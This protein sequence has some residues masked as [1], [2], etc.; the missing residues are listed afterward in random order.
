MPT[1]HATTAASAVATAMSRSRI[2]RRGLG[3]GADWT[4]SRPTREGSLRIVHR[5]HRSGTSWFNGC[6]GAP[7]RRLSCTMLDHSPECV[8]WR[9]LAVHHRR[10]FAI[11]LTD[12]DFEMSGR[13][14]RHFEAP[15]LAGKV[16]VLGDDIEPCVDE[17]PRDLGRLSQPDRD[18]RRRFACVELH[19]VQ[20][21]DGRRVGEQ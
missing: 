21:P 20:L 2:P 17:E 14:T 9:Q 6:L 8:L 7:G 3:N 16:I 19:P 12:T 18:E 11:S 1:E 10:Q 5:S 4:R 13:D 15:Q